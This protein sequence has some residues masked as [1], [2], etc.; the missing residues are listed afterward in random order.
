M[1]HR[2][3]IKALCGTSMALYLAGCSLGSPKPET[4]VIAVPSSKPYR[5]IKPHPTE[6]KLSA[7][8]L[9]QISRHN[10]THA[11]VKKKEAEAV[12]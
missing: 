6:D 10:T 3:I 9:A 7:D 8:T 11:L 1:V 2:M 12:K 4:R 5:Y